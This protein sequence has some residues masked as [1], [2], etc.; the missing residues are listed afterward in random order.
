VSTSRVE[1]QTS[2]QP[3]KPVSF[4]TCDGRSL[5]RHSQRPWLRSLQ[6]EVPISTI[7]RVFYLATFT[8]TF[9]ADQLLKSSKPPLPIVK[10]GP[11]VVPQPPG[12]PALFKMNDLYS[13]GNY[14]GWPLERVCNETKY[15]PG[16]VFMC[17]DNFRGI[18]NIPNLILTCV[19]Y[20]IDAGAT[21]IIPPKSNDIQ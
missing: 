7:F 8:S 9:K 11:P 12:D 13:N 3:L 1:R 15:Q 16:L 6:S 20:A 17:D 14:V 2:P 19:R 5:C 18:G 4:Y 21:D 10:S